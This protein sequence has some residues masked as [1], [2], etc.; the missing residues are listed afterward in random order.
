MKRF[1][2]FSLFLLVA[3]LVSIGCFASY[4]VAQAATLTSTNVEPASLIASATSQVTISFTTIGVI[5]PG[6]KVKVTFGVGFNVTGANGGSCSTFLDDTDFLTDVTD[7]IV[8]I[9]RVGGTAT[10][11]A[12]AETCTIDGIINPASAGSTG[13]YTITT[14]DASNVTIDNDVAV[15]ADIITA[16]TVPTLAESTVIPVSTVKAEDLKVI[17]A[18]SV[19]NSGES[20]DTINQFRIENKSLLTAVAADMASVAIY[21]DSST[22]GI[23]DGGDTLAC[24][25]S[26]T[27]TTT[28]FDAGGSLINF[29]CS[30][31]ISIGAGATQN[32]LAVITTTV[33]ATNGRTMA[34]MVNAHF[35]A[36]NTWAASDLETT[37]PI[38][39]D[40]VTP[41]VTSVVWTPAGGHTVI[42]AGDAVV[43]TFSEEMDTS[44][45]TTGN[46]VTLATEL[47]LSAGIFG[48]TGFSAAWNG[49]TNTILTI[50]L[51]TE[52]T[53]LSG[54]TIDPTTAV[55]DVAGN[56]DNTTPAVAIL[57]NVA[58]IISPAFVVNN[59]VQPNTVTVTASEPINSSEAQDSTNWI[60]TNNDGSVS[61]TIV[62]AVLSGGN[63]VTLTL[64]AVNPSTH[65][66]FITNA[67][68]DAHIKVT[69]G[70]GIH[71][72]AAGTPNASAGAIVTGAGETLT[73]DVTAPTAIL[74]Y[75]KDGGVSYAT[76]KS[77]KVG[78]T[79]KIKA[80]FNE[81]IADAPVMKL[82]IDNSV[83]S[84][85]NMTKVSA[86]VY[87]YDLTAPVGNIA[88]AA[89]SLSVGT[90]VAGNLVSVATP[91]NPSFVIDNTAPTIIIG[92]DKATLKKNETAA[93]TFTLLESS[94]NFAAGD[95]SVAG[96]IL[97]AFAGSETS[98]T[99]TFTPTDEST[100]MATIDV[101]A[102]T[103][104]DAAANDNVAAPQFSM[105][106]DTIA[107]TLV[108]AVFTD[109]ALKVGETSLVTFTF[110]ESI[111]GFANADLTI[112]NGGL[113]A[114]TVDGVD[115]TVY[116]A[117]FTPTTGIEEATNVITVAM[118]G[119]A[120]TAGNA[121]IGT[122]PSSNYAID[123]LAPSVPT[124]SPVAD[125]YTSVQSVTLSSTGSTSI[126]YTTDGTD[127][128]TCSSGSLSSGVISVSSSQTI[129][130]RGCDAA[131]N[132]STLS[133]FTYTISI[134]SSSGGGG[135]NVT[136]ACTDVVYGDYSTACFG[137]YQ[138]RSAVSRTPSNCALTAAQQET[139]KRVCSTPADI[140]NVNVNSNESPATPLTITPTTCNICQ[141]L[142]YDVYIINPDESERHTGTPWVRVTD[143]GNGIKRYSFEDKTL[144]PQD[145]NYDYNDFVIDVDLK[146]CQ[147]VK[148]MFVSSDA[149]W[150]HQVRVRVLINGVK[151]SD[152][153][154]ADDSKAVVGTFKTVNAAGGVDIRFV[155]SA[156]PA[157][158]ASSL[159]GKIL[160]Q[161]QAHGEA[162]YVNPL[163]GQRYY[164]ANGD[165]VYDVMR[166]FG[167]GITNKNLEKIKSSKT[168]AKSNSGKIFLQVESRGEAYYIDF[169]GI[170]HYLKDGAA[171]YEVMGS[172]GLGI[173]NS[174]LDKITEGNL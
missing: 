172:L 173:T 34:A 21:S 33:G 144:N 80:T 97:S 82:A 59:Q 48:A 153:L 26:T 115:P 86:T 116:T 58:P 163:D 145:P 139:A 104:T 71:D 85:T 50:T 65:G 39:I 83:L 169:N 100:T 91:T 40:T 73:K 4:Q 75:S 2:K 93:I 167:I 126:R 53:I 7:Q 106:V 111:T 51:G 8:I 45:L 32:Y 63:I 3:A 127:P 125:T 42:S 19:T 102:A 128:S 20:S 69:M 12:H 22:L 13:A 10:V 61:R 9:T 135:G 55:K 105:T 134:S 60:I 168:F 79:L 142:T 147:R 30:S 158:F 70:A 112:A 96:G 107:P 130:A 162:W 98:Y 14:T 114:V 164:L 171:A 154:M 170:A 161:V 157:A 88:T 152:T 117:T 109:N 62:S 56:S 149:A 118:T 137:D 28:N 31:P 113:T 66:T 131:G 57:D 160:L 166:N 90:D 92:S 132:I 49:P 76:T 174:N 156:E 101:V 81:A 23:I 121:G 124:A 143:R 43:V 29:T 15:T 35:F 122:T 129:K 18:F 150:K 94:V 54:A 46:P 99:A 64:A 159:K 1:K 36:A 78:D 119:V 165:K 5:P 16:A 74:T 103:F 155:C 148:F 47:G 38:T 27:N 123:T 87:T 41:T 151:Q 11:A 140:N 17:G 52:T 24:A 120:D 37:N 25:E 77:V 67:D 138:Y 136:P 108:S 110:S 95:V 68:A 133:S 72:L 146:N 6:G 141:K 44:T 84:A 89:V